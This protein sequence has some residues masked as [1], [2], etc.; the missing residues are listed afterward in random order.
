[1][2]RWIAARLRGLAERLD[3]QEATY[4][5]VRSGSFSGLMRGRWYPFAA[6]REHDSGVTYGNGDTETN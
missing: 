2:R 4:L 5:L 6:D 3:P 1:M